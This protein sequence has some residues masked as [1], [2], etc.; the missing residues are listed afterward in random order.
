MGCSNVSRAAYH[1]TAHGFGHVLTRSL[2]AR[3]LTELL[4]I[5]A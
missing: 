2:K 3:S 1:R 4:P 5:R